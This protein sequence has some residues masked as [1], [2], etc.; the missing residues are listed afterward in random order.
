MCLF[1]LSGVKCFIEG[2]GLRLAWKDLDSPMSHVGRT[3]VFTDVHVNTCIHPSIN[4]FVHAC[5]YDDMHTYLH[6]DKH[7]NSEPKEH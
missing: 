6:S 4:E 3:P 5:M 2:R 1:L 7:R